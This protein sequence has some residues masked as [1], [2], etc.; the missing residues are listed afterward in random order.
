MGRIYPLV[1]VTPLQHK[2]LNVFVS[3][4]SCWTVVLHS[5][6]WLTILKFGSIIQFT[7]SSL[8]LKI[9]IL[10]FIIFATL[11]LRRIKTRP[12]NLDLSFSFLLRNGC[13]ES[14]VI[15]SIWLVSQNQYRIIS[16][17]N[18]F[19][20][21]VSNFYIFQLWGR[22][23]IKTHSFH[24]LLIYENKNQLFLLFYFHYFSLPDF[25]FILVLPLLIIVKRGLGILLLISLVRGN[26][27]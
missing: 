12:S 25:I 15:F 22:I 5:I 26:I 24:N 27:I 21:Y 23:M 8:F 13:F 16:S 9:S 19:S 6:V 7:M 18:R 17:V 20:R 10:T 14:D 2:N 11:V 4:N 3:V 1:I